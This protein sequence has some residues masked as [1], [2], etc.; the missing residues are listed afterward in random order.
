MSVDCRRLL[1]IYYMIF[2]KFHPVHQVLKQTVKLHEC[3]AQIF[4]T[5]NL[6][7]FNVLNFASL[8]FI[9]SVDMV[10][11]DI[12]NTLPNADNSMSILGEFI[13]YL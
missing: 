1:G 12:G 10:L 13:V 9:F 11:P 8:F 7:F 3:C 6:F 4:G 2:I 5:L